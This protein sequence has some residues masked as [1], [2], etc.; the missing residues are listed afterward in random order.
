MSTLFAR[1]S[2]KRMAFIWTL[3]LVSI[4]QVGYCLT[5]TVT[6]TADSGGGTLR[7]GITQVNA[8][9][10]DTIDFN[11]PTSDG[12]YNPA[13]NTWSIAPATELPPSPNR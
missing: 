1:Y 13:K 2:A 5:Y 4:A 6:S 9:L 10:Y 11:I 8:G 3:L 7:F 12:G